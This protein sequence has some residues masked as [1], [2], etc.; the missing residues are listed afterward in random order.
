[1]DSETRAACT[2]K[3]NQT[4]FLLA[5]VEPEHR[6]FNLGTKSTPTEINKAIRSGNSHTSDMQG[7]F[8]PDVSVLKQS[9]LSDTLN[10]LVV[11]HASEE[12]ILEL[13]HG[14]QKDD[15]CKT[16]K[17]QLIS[18][19]RNQ[20]ST[21][22]NDLQ[23]LKDES[24]CDKG[25]II[26]SKH[27]DE[28]VLASPTEFP[29]VDASPSSSKNPLSRRKDK[30]NVLCDDGVSENNLKDEDDSHESVES[31]NS[32]GKFSA[33]KIKWSFEN[34]HF[35][36]LQRQDSSFMNWISNMIKGLSKSN[37]EDTPSLALTTKTHNCNR[38]SETSAGFQTIFKALYCP[39]PRVQDDRVFT[40]DSQLGEGS[41]ELDNSSSPS[42]GDDNGKC[43]QIVLYSSPGCSMNMLS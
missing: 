16:N 8:S 29:A 38:G 17:T 7:S 27:A 12:E 6:D 23:L 5:Q 25:G 41:K 26:T 10:P 2:S 24:A 28:E 15:K 36:P 32:T 9:K 13:A 30:V 19:L 14:I 21:A 11:S 4:K 18:P 3:S 33:G 40:L 22:E 42:T 34:P 37:L 1:P 35:G 43:K 31:C 20:E 39:N